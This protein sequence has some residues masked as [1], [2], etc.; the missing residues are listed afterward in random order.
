[1]T[2]QTNVPDWIL[3]SYFL[4]NM[5]LNFLNFYWFFKMIQALRRRFEPKQEKIT[6]ADVNI[7]SLSS[8]TA[9]VTKPRLRKA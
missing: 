3:Y 2:D 6:E 8:G 4:S 5:T 9:Q 1:V 7:A